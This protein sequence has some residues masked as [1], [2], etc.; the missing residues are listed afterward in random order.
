[1]IETIAVEEAIKRLGLPEHTEFTGYVV[2]LPEADEF[3][4][5]FQN[6]KEH[7]SWMWSK[8]PQ[9]AKVYQ[10][11]KKAEKV[12]KIYGKGAL[13]VLLFDTGDQYVVQ[14]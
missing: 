10:S 5:M 8:T 2:H 1:M 7:E 13:V 3:L 9:M 4:S 6:D 14:P 11:R 12:A